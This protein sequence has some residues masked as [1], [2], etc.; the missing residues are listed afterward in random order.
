LSI[1]FNQKG[2]HC[3]FP[4]GNGKIEEKDSDPGK[5]QEVVQLTNF[6]NESDMVSQAVENGEKT[7]DLCKHCEEL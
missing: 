2:C 6:L 7:K 4:S 5:E 3:D 1:H